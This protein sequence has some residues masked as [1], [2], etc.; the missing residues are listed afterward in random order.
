MYTH[1]A[2]DSIYASQVRNP[3]RISTRNVLWFCPDHTASCRGPC[4]DRKA[5]QVYF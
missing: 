4:S 2:F 5:C 3:T 1:S